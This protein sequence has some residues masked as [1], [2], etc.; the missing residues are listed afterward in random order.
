VR[1]DAQTA[2]PVQPEQIADLGGDMR[3]ISVGGRLAYVGE[4]IGGSGVLSVLDLSSTPR[5]VGRVALPGAVVGMAR[6]G[7]I[8]YAG[9]ELQNGFDQ[10]VLVDVTNVL[11]PVLRGVYTLESTDTPTQ[12]VAVGSRLYFGG[13]DYAGVTLLN[14][15]NPDS[16]SFVKIFGAGS[17]F[18]ARDSSASHCPSMLSRG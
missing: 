7:S 18:I 4:N 9:V 1:A 6:A 17:N 10:I 14:V 12:L 13:G 11:S 5:R 2:P 16:P 3:R 8:V 15:S